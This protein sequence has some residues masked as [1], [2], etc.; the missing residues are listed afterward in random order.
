MA[1]ET[2]RHGGLPPSAAGRSGSGLASRDVRRGELAFEFRGQSRQDV[3]RKSGNSERLSH[4]SAGAIG[5]CVDGDRLSGDLAPGIGAQI[6][7]HIGDTLRADEG[8]ER[9]VANGL[10][11]QFLDGAPGSRRSA[12]ITRSMR[13]PSTDPGQTALARIP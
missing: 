4:L 12:R 6:H 3:A 13:S 8:L 9:C 7:D 10:G 1:R 2:A 11:A 5:K